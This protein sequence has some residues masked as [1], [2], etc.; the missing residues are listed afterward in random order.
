MG[1]ASRRK[2]L[3]LIVAA[4]CA[5][6]GD[7]DELEAPV[8]IDCEAAFV[9]LLELGD[10]E[11][12]T[13]VLRFE[14]RALLFTA[15]D[16][17][18]GKPRLRLTRIDGCGAEAVMVFQG[19][20]RVEEPSSSAAAP[21]VVWFGERDELDRPEL[22][23]YD[24]VGDRSP[25]RIPADLEL[26]GEV[27]GELYFRRG[28]EQV[29]VTYGHDGLGEPV[30]IGRTGRFRFE[31]GERRYEI[32]ERRQFVATDLRTQQATVVFRDVDDASV[33]REHGV[34]FVHGRRYGEWRH[35][36]WEPA[37]GRVIVQPLD[38]D[39]RRE[40]RRQL[41]LE[42]QL[43]M[44]SVPDDWIIDWNRLALATA[45]DGTALFAVAGELYIVAPDAIEPF[46]IG[47]G[48][49][50][51]DISLGYWRGE[52]RIHE[53]GRSS[54]GSRTYRVALDGTGFTDLY[55]RD[56]DDARELADGRWALLAAGELVLHD[57]QTGS[58]RTIWPAGYGAVELHRER[59]GMSYDDIVFLG[60]GADEALTLYRVR[61]DRLD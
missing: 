44:M 15:L 20:E 28:D 57:V 52:F 24:V 43:R 4:A 2:V 40:G 33:I 25:R 39:L 51:E 26:L 47:D 55:G 30:V 9:P 56:V 17:E 23:V 46:W 61:P 54:L 41:L 3:G 13:D 36:A 58:D 7:G 21:W 32:D 38:E 6:T 34:F 35:W 10:D 1:V 50:A 53:L 37:T 29:R 19:A 45:P 59:Y 27:D 49:A 18:A 8:G 14:D 12:D 5:P 42:P 48:I 11:R 31:D 60:A 22:W 16:D